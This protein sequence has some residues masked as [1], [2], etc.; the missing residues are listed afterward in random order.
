MVPGTPL[1]AADPVLEF[2][3]AFQGANGFFCAK[4]DWDTSQVAIEG[5]GPAPFLPPSCA[6][7]TAPVAAAPYAC[8]QWGP[9]QW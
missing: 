9:A 4:S 8:A 2:P 1:I 6:G 5:V 3:A 7:P